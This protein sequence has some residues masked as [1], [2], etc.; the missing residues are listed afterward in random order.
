MEKENEF[1]TFPNLD[2]R[3]DGILQNSLQLALESFTKCNVSSVVTA[4]DTAKQIIW[5]C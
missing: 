5:C 4:V 3:P 2:L 1:G